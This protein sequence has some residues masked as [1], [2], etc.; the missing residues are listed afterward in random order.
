LEKRSAKRRKITGDRLPK[1][2]RREDI[3]RGPRI[4]VPGMGRSRKVKGPIRTKRNQ[5]GGTKKKKS[6]L[7]H[8]SPG[9]GLPFEGRKRI[10]Q[11][12][13]GKSRRRT[14]GKGLMPRSLEKKTWEKSWWGVGT[15]EKTAAP[16]RRLRAADG[17]QKGKPLRKK[18]SSQSPGQDEEGGESEGPETPQQDY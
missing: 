14:G 11:K 16:G 7:D 15:E 13:K 4:E 12:K 6:R 18:G 3:L 8:F 1:R 17:K 10:A 2:E 9:G 5:G